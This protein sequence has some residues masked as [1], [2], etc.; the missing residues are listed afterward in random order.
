MKST[1]QNEEV[2]SLT[3]AYFVVILSEINNE[4]EEKDV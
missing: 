3:T 2:I 4:G 1:L